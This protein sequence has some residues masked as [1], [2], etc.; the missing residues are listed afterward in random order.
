MNRVGNFRFPWVGKIG[1]PLTRM[2]D[3][4]KQMLARQ[5]RPAGDAE[6][7]A[8]LERL[9]QRHEAT[10]GDLL[11]ILGAVLSEQVPPDRIPEALSRAHE[12]LVTARQEIESL[13]RWAPA[14]PDLRPALDRAATALDSHGEINLEQ[15][16]EALASARKT[17]R[18]FAHRNRL[19]DAE[20]EWSLALHEAKL[21]TARQRYGEAAELYHRAC[22]PLL[23]EQKVLRVRALLL[24]AK[25]RDD[26]GDTFGGTA[27]LRLAVQD[28]DAALEYSTKHDTP[29]DWAMTHDMRAC[30][31]RVLGQRL[32]GEEG[33][34]ILQEAVWGCEAALEIS[35]R[36][37]GRRLRTT[38]R[39]RFRRWANLWGARKSCACCVRQ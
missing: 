30:T 37:I 4:L 6:V 28:Y 2:E 16:Q 22:E 13:R 18:S 27:S 11:G 3:M 25:A 29:L 12:A 26:Q 34:K 38:G 33:L 35:C 7:S 23:P 21:A 10:T 19:R 1:F 17:F 24:A 31:L 5:G 39:T 15:A 32:G 36:P 14:Y 9:K 8:E 20:M